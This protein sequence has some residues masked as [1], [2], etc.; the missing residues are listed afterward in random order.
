MFKS[1]G[2]DQ[3]LVSLAADS[4]ITNDN[5][6]TSSLAH[7]D[8]Y[9]VYDILYGR[10]KSLTLPAF[11]IVEN[12]GA[13]VIEADGTAAFKED[14]LVGFL[15][16]EESKYFLIASGE[17]QGGILALALKGTGKPDTSLEISSSS[18]K[19]SFTNDGGKLAF[20]IE[21]ETDVY[22]AETMA[23]IDVM[24]EDQIKALEEE[25]GKRLE[26]EI[27]ALIKRVQT[28]LKTDIFG[29]GL[30]IHQRDLAL[31]RQV[32]NQWDTYFE[33][34][35]ISVSCKVNIKNTAYITSKEDIKF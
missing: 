17:C 33:T 29:F 7:K 32:E 30:I 13:K 21:T 19:T 15:S 26:L 27:N 22:L 1:E 23:D 16:P 31:W 6:I 34:L 9:L 18:V 5:K 8:L 25:A 35:P 3:V 20:R 11:H 28:E 4:I 12:A 2:T 10:G 14:K 24:K